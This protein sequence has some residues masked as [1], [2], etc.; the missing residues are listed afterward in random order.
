MNAAAAMPTY[1]IISMV[2]NWRIVQLSELFSVGCLIFNVKKLNIYIGLRDFLLQ[3]PPG[4]TKNRLSRF[5][6]AHKKTNNCNMSLKNN[7][8]ERRRRRPLTSFLDKKTPYDSIQ[9]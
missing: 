7:L 4:R 2:Y 5:I 3:G 9:H 1:A 8:L 6:E